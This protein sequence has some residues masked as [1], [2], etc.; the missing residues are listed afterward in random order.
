MHVSEVGPDRYPELVALGVRR[1]PTVAASDLEWPLM[2]RDSWPDL[3]ALAAVEG[4]ELLGW[5]WMA[6]G[7][8]NP[9]GWLNL[10]VTV[11]AGA[12]GAGVGSALH[13]GLLD[14]RPTDA[15]L[16]RSEVR[17]DEGRSLEVARHWGYDVEELSITSELPLVDL[18]APTPA[19]GVVLEVPSSLAF[20]DQEA[21][22]RMLLASQTNPEARAGSVLDCDKLTK[23]TQGADH[24]VYVLARVGGVPAALLAGVVVDESLFVAYTGVDPAFRGRGLAVLTKQQAHLEAA[25]HGAMTS[26]TD[27]EENNAGIRR[28]NR[29]LGYQVTYGSYRL[30]RP[31]ERAR[32]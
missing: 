8:H 26:R 20:P 23:V 2:V 3:V 31:V 24:A 1:N 19:E 25:R 32:S 10:W 16:L 27:N 11:A 6:T 28:V 13:R 30:R 17:S 22:E 4:E 14:R 5:G 7:T 29:E 9:A 12:E 21:V 18:P 15:V